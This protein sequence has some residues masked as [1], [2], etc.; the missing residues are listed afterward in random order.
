VEAV[1][2]YRNLYT[3]VHRQRWK[4]RLHTSNNKPHGPPG[5]WTAA[6]LADQPESNYPLKTAGVVF[7]QTA[8]TKF[9]GFVNAFKADPANVLNAGNLLAAFNN[10]PVHVQEE[11]LEIAG[12]SAYTTPRAAYWHGQQAAQPL[13]ELVAFYGFKVCDLAPEQAHGGVI[14]AVV[15]SVCI[16]APQAFLARFCDGNEPPNPHLPQNAID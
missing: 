3:A 12:V 14:A 7:L 1:L 2:F 10:Q 11:Q 4:N 13:D 5:A 9:V 8:R 6:A 16:L 15:K